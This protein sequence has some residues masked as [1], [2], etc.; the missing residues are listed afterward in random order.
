MR[1]L[2]ALFAL[3]ACSSS[4]RSKTHSFVADTPCG[5][6]PYDIHL[7]ADGKTGEEG[8]EVIACT[9]HRLV[10]TAELRIDRS[11]L[12][13]YKF[14]D[15]EPAENGRCLASPATVASVGSASA[16]SSAGA[17]GNA[18]STGSRATPV[19][20]ERA[21]T[22]S[23]TPF[24]DEL[25]KQYGLAAQ[26]VM[27]ATLTRTEPGIDL[28]VRLWSDVPNDLEGTVF[29]IR[30]LT[31]KKSKAEVDKEWEELAQEQAKKPPKDVPKDPRRVPEHDA[32][33]APLVEAR[34]AQP[35]ANATWIAGYWQWTGSQWGWVAGFWRDARVAMPEP[36]LEVP[37][38]MPSA[39]AVWVGGS[40]QLRAGAWIWVRGHWR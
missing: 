9:A 36:R 35:T 23:E 1:C 26:T 22:G 17:S 24:P 29:L 16:A 19:L 27:T 39:A 34:P 11:L 40:W 18:K 12:Q 30:H 7:K 32:P 37:G 28:H 8:V 5:Q 4:L 13:S 25:C 10:G 31:S 15:G 33:P 3:T 2:L 14:G 21:Y 38:Q 20:V 6:G